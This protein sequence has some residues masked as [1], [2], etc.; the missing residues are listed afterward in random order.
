MGSILS[1]WQRNKHWLIAVICCL[2]VLTGCGRR[3]SSG[4][5]AAQEADL[6]DI[7]ALQRAIAEAQN[8]VIAYVK[9][10]TARWVQHELSWWYRYTHRSEQHVEYRLISPTD[11]LTHTIHEVVYDLQGRM[12]VDAVRSF[13]N[14]EEEP[15]CYRI[16]MGELVEGDTVQLLIPWNM[17]YGAQ[18]ND[19]VPACTN[20]RVQLCKHDII[21]ESQ[22]SIVESDE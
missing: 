9:A 5:S 6:T 13:R 16:M 11:T 2:A 22:K 1:G 15:F 3:P 21:V 19:H 8:A 14:S 18:G 17:G 12:I 10:D 4:K 20:L 7:F